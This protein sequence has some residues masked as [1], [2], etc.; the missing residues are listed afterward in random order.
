M[1]Y[2]TAD[3][4]ITIK[5][6]EVRALYLR[7]FPETAP[8][9]LAQLRWR[10]LVTRLIQHHCMRREKLNLSPEAKAK[11]NGTPEGLL[12]DWIVLIKGGVNGFYHCKRCGDK[13]AM[14]VTTMSFEMVE[15]LLLAYKRDHI[16]CKEASSES[17]T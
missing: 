13:T 5:T 16:N 1:P 2:L 12:A 10:T 7:C 6:R 9:R 14:P 4:V 17:A 3:D 8:G 15:S 11:Y